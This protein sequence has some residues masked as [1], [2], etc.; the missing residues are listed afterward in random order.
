V[1]RDA[2]AFAAA[3]HA[4]FGIDP[5]DLQSGSIGNRRVTKADTPRSTRPATTRST[6]TKRSATRVCS[7]SPSRS[8]TEEAARQQR[9]F[10]A[11]VE[12]LAKVS[13]T[14]SLIA[15]YVILTALPIIIAGD[16]DQK[17]H[18]LEPLASG[19]K[20]GSYALTEPA[21][22]SD[23][24]A[25]QTR[26]ERHGDSWVLNGEKRFVGLADIYV[27]FARTG[28]PGPKGISAFVV[29]GDAEG[30]SV[31]R[32]RTMGMPGWQLGS[33][34]FNDVEVPAENMLGAEGAGFKIA[35]TT[36]DH[37][38]PTVAAQ[39]VG[40]GQGAIDLALDYAVRRQTFGRPLFAHE[41]IQFKLA[42][43]EAEVTAAR[44]LTFQAATF[45]DEGDPRVTKLSAAAKLFASDVARRV[46]T[47]AV[48][49]GRPSNG[50]RSGPSTC[51]A[52][53][54]SPPARRR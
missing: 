32:L 42:G 52:P 48:Q 19:T 51:P 18:F 37:S 30:L 15:A 24:A 40:V 39:S 34:L 49:D 1:V 11:Y 20:L 36:F 4:R 6:S 21:V 3:L 16:E 23:P 8:C 26:A 17:R 35:M 14:A 29:P 33:P 9:A 7:G 28:D 44:A 54:A 22:G 38:R 41:G 5:A 46:T 27:V 53:R 13:A 12:K 25:L 43:L 45:V 47:E 31:E 2:R 10:C 50:R